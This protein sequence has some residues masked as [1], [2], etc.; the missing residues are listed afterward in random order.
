MDLRDS[1]VTKKPV[2][3]YMAA[4]DAF[5]LIFSAVVYFTNI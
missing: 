1:S 5:L 2:N 4:L 3:A